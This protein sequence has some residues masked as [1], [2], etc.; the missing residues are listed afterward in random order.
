MKAGELIKYLENFDAEL[1]VMFNISDIHLEEFKSAE[2][3]QVVDSGKS[4]HMRGRFE[5][6]YKGKTLKQR[7]GEPIDALVLHYDD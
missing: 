7:Y 3:E 4:G 2:I 6:F 1:P 5:E